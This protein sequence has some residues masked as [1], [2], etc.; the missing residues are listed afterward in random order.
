MSRI[1]NSFES[2]DR[3]V[4][5]TVGQPGERAFYIQARY[6]GTLVTVAIEKTQAQALVE[7]LQILLK[8]IRKKKEVE[9]PQKSIS[10]RDD[11][12]LESP[13]EEDF[14][15]GVM[16]I[17]WLNAEAKIMIEAQAISEEIILD[18]TDSETDESDPK[19]IPDDDLAGPDLLRVKLSITQVKE[20]IARTTA[21]IDAGRAPCAFCGIPIDPN[22][23]L[24]PRANGYRR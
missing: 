11:Q 14:R 2:V 15:V 24:C 19:L 21:V 1:I 5:G 13:I 16:A 17:T 9:I 22:G 7:R 8:E 3:F 18:G 12:P 10:I 23:H 20:F 6:S 4:T